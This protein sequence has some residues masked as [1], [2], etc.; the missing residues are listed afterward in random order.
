M[1]RNDPWDVWVA[2]NFGKPLLNPPPH[3]LYDEFPLDPKIDRND[4]EA[5]FDEATSSLSGIQCEDGFGPWESLGNYVC[6]VVQPSRIFSPQDLEEYLRGKG[7]Y[8]ID[9]FAYGQPDGPGTPGTIWVVRVWDLRRECEIANSRFV[10]DKLSWAMS[11][12][13]LLIP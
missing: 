13:A 4:P 3:P 7:R 1:D 11:V 5:W 2:E 6:V 10:S 12:V 8:T 9:F